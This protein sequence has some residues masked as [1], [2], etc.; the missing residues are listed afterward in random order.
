MPLFKSFF[1]RMSF[2]P[3]KWYSTELQ[4]P[5]KAEWLKINW[6]QVSS[7][8]NQYHAAD[9]KGGKVA[10]SNKALQ[11]PLRWSKG[12][13]NP[14]PGKLKSKLKSSMA[15]AIWKYWTLINHFI[16]HNSRGIQTCVVNNAFSD[17][18]ATQSASLVPN[19]LSWEPQPLL[20]LSS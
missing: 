13:P 4:L 7:Q 5:K 8:R 12:L 11:L 20:A 1:H 10:E 19:H 2:S 15:M 17:L 18:Q 6:L 3:G 9:M 14:G 16:L